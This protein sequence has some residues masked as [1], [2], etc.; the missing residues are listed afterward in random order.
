MYRRRPGRRDRGDPLHRRGRRRLHL[1]GAVDTEQQQHGVRERRLENLQPGGRRSRRVTRDG[2]GSHQ[3]DDGRSAEGQQAAVGPAAGGEQAADGPAEGGQRAA[4]E[5]PADGLREEGEEHRRSRGRRGGCGA[6]EGLEASRGEVVRDRRG[7]NRGG[8]AAEVR[9]LR[10]LREVGE[11]RR[12]GGQPG[13]VPVLRQ[14]PPGQAA[15]Q[16]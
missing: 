13:L 14:E 7:G 6:G 10:P 16:W 12:E 2:R 5:G 11:A 15:G 8:A 3:G 4:D 1:H 9:Q